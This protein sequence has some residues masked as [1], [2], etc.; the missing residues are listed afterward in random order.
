ML[1]SLSAVIHVHVQHT[2]NDKRTRDAYC[3]SVIVLFVQFG[4]HGLQINFY[5]L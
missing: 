4:R 2:G 1:E 3:L 5:A